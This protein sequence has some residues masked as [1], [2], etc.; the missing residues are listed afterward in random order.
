MKPLYLFLCFLLVFGCTTND[1][2]PTN[3]TPPETSLYFPPITENTWETT[4]PESLNWNATALDELYTYL[5]EKNT[6]GFIILKHG[7]IVIERYFNGH[8]QNANWAWFSAVK[9][10]TATAIG[11]AQDENLININNK[12]SD[13]LGNN[14]SSLTQSQQDLI[15]VKHHLQ[16]TTGLQNTPQNILAWTCFGPL[17]MLYDADA[18]TKWQYHQGAFTQLQRMLSQN[19][20]VN[21]REYIRTKI[22][23]NIGASGSW[24]QLLGVNIFSSNTR[25]MAR[26]GL[27]MLNKGKWDD[28]TIVSESYYNEMINASQNLN[29]SYGYLWWLNGKESFMSTSDQTVFDGS[30]IPNAPNDMI[31]A[32]GAQDQKIYVVPSLDLVIVRTGE[33]AG[34]EELAN[35]S[36]DNELWLK[37]NAVIN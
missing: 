13:Y 22:L 2:N 14:W 4:L 29:K 20:G 35:S 33:A 19:T 23:N 8:N 1:S 21:F 30:L 7:R 5:N 9:S 17:C 27:L 18:G 15:T 31:A 16:M 11:V 26:F 25:S 24:N 28:N 36:F 3:T 10:L 6:K 32:L 12:T 37:I 34:V